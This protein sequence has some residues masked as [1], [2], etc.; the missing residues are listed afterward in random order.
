MR[1]EKGSRPLRTSSSVLKNVPTA[2]PCVWAAAAVVEASFRLRPKA[3]DIPS[4]W[5]FQAVR[6]VGCRGGEAALGAVGMQTDEEKH[7]RFGAIC[8]GAGGREDKALQSESP[9]YSNRTFRPSNLDILLTSKGI[10]KVR[11]ICSA[12]QHS[13]SAKGSNKHVHFGI[14]PLPKTA[15]T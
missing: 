9:P 4:E 2:P 11:V 12:V 1:V 7:F 3:H 14:Q 13:A 6:H 15:G 8:G 10:A 5:R